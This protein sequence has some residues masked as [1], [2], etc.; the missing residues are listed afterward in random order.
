MLN[1]SQVD[2][3]ALQ[4]R[5]LKV[6][7]VALFYP[8]V[9]AY[10]TAPTLGL[11]IRYQTLS[12]SLQTG[13]SSCDMSSFSINSILDLH[14][15]KCCSSSTNH[16]AKNAIAFEEL[17]EQVLS[18]EYREHSRSPNLRPSL[19]TD[20]SSYEG[21]VY[22]LVYLTFTSLPESVTCFFIPQFQ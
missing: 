22:T 10:F 20:D 4:P 14:D 6:T 21:K 12:L 13:W 1:V 11:K 7:H 15:S 16:A 8:L 3:E 18:K 5:L 19:E 2:T 9:R 17:E